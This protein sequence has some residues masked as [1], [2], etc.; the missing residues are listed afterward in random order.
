M[1][2]EMT[3]GNATVTAGRLLYDGECAFCLGWARRMERVLGLN[4]FALAPLQSRERRRLAGEA[5]LK[6]ET[7]WQDASAPKEIHRPGFTEMILELPDGRELGGA[8]A[9]MEIARH[10][11]WLWPLWLASR[12][13]GAMPVFR[14]A[15]RFIARHRHYFANSCQG[16]NCAQAQHRHSAFFEMP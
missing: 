3:D 9:A 2:T 7:R 14:A 10:I 15:Y 12:I 1:I 4:G 5:S 11:W 6:T 16:K 13:P 8:D